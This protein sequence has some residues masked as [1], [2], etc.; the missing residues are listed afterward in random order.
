[1]LPQKIH[2]KQT[3]TQIIEKDKGI[4]EV[5]GQFTNEKYLI[6]FP[7]Q[8]KLKNVYNAGIN[9]ILPSSVISQM[10]GGETESTNVVKVIRE[11]PD[12]NFE[13]KVAAT[14]A[15]KLDVLLINLATGG[16]PDLQQLLEENN[17]RYGY[18][19]SIDQLKKLIN[20]NPIKLIII[21]SNG[22]AVKSINFSYK[23]NRILGQNRV[24][25]WLQSSDWNMGLIERAIKSGASYLVVTPLNFKIIKKKIIQLF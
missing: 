1:M 23:I 4:Q 12:N 5:L 20:S 3:N 7:F 19:N 25:I 10:A 14:S 16:E 18:V 2:L 15:D 22:Q 21:Q 11:K 6:N 24:P 9:L 13:N 8:L 17:I